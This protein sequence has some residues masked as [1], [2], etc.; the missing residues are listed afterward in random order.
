MKNQINVKSVLSKNLL[1]IEL[2]KHRQAKIREIIDRNDDSLAC[3]EE[4]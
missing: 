3:F 2:V 1:D 4:I